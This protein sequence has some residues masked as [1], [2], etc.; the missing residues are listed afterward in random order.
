M[1]QITSPP[2][3]YRIPKKLERLLTGFPKEKKKPKD[4]KNNGMNVQ[5]LH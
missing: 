3:N 5:M 4:F 2:Q 1:T